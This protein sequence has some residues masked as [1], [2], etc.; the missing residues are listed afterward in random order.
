MGFAG[1]GPGLAR[2]RHRR[3]RDG[4][5]PRRGCLAVW[6]SGVELSWW[7][8]GSGGIAWAV[9]EWV[10]AGPGLDLGEGKA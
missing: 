5:A 8:G 3:D 1:W 6:W 4:E 7:S 10:G 9:G 2:S